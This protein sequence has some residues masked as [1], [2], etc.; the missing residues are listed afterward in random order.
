MS[1]H[2]VSEPPDE[3]EAADSA[4]PGRVR[5][6]VWALCARRMR[7]WRVPPHWTPS[8]WLEEM[9][10]EGAIAALQATLDFDPAR[11]VPIEAYMYQRVMGRLIARYR[12][13]WKYALHETPSGEIEAIPEDGQVPAPVGLWE[14]LRSAVGQLADI[15]RQLIHCLF[16]KK[17]TEA[18]VAKTLGVSQQAINKR[19]HAILKF[20]NDWISTH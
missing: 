4:R 8:Q 16:W 3:P 15:D 20:L 10:A 9:K 1:V 11:N 2:H 5:D 6:R 12:K 18:E 17:N 14:D 13:E 19:K 7:N